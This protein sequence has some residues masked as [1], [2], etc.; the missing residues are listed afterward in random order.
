MQMTDEKA[1][2]A[3]AFISLPPDIYRTP[4]DFALTKKVPLLRKPS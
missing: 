1:A 3:R 2:S 4:G